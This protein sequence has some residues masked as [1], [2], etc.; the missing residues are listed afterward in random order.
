MDIHDND[1]AIVSLQKEFPDKDVIY[2][3]TDVMDNENVKTSFQFVKTRFG[4][5]D[6]VIGN[7]GVADES[8]PQHTIQVNLVNSVESISCTLH[9]LAFDSKQTFAFRLE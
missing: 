4:H 7:A 6:I 3:Q 9:Y 8:N 2:V 5:F 1:D